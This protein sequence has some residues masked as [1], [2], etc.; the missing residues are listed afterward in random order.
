MIVAIIQARMS[1]T[2]LP[3]KVLRPILG[4]EMLALQVERVRRC[5][6]LDRVVVATS[7]QNEDNPIANLCKSIDQPVFR[8]SLYNVLDRF[9][10]TSKEYKATHIVRLTG[11]CP[12]A[13]AGLIDELV[14]FYLNQACDY[15]SNCRPPTLPDG[16]DAE[17]FS[18]S[19]L[20]CAWQQATTPFEL[21]HVVPYIINHPDSFY[22]ANYEYHENLS[23]F[24]WT[25]DQPEDFLFVSRIY[26]MLYPENPSFDI[27]DII[28]LLKEDPKLLKINGQFKRQAMLLKTNGKIKDTEVQRNSL[29]ESIRK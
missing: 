13:D 22:L 24:R 21:E 10:Q 4:R 9:Y 25:V 23:H 2:R 26:E 3:G 5:R 20:K 8:G 18:F 1:S 27:D 16:L 14:T 7:D 17:I 29:L 11:D 19:T 28:K 12:L 15:A 6:N